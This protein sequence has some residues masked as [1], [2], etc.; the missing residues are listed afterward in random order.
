MKK[1]TMIMRILYK[2]YTNCTQIKLTGASIKVTSAQLFLARE[3][4]LSKTNKEDDYE[5]ESS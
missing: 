2:K 1:Y 4:C 3:I 5:K